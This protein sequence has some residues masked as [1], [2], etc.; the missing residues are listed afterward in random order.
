MGLEVE[1]LDLPGIGLVRPEAACRGRNLFETDIYAKQNGLAVLYSTQIN[2]VASLLERETPCPEW[3]SQEARRLKI[4]EGAVEKAYTNFRGEVWGRYFIRSGELLAWPP[5][6]QRICNTRLS[7]R[8]EKPVLLGLYEVSEGG[9]GE[10]TLNGGE[11][12]EVEWPKE[13]SKIPK[14][15]ISTFNAKT[16]TEVW[17]GPYTEKAEGLRTLIWEFRLAQGKNPQKVILSPGWTPWDSHN[18]V[19]SVL[20]KK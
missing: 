20:R 3:V 4:R 6:S 18:A 1:Y 13:S 10:Y 14:K 9:N 16:E 2:A 8:S 5:Y 17:G 19:G 15:L 12:I 7:G 11:A